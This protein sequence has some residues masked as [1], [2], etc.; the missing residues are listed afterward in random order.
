[1]ARDPHTDSERA[2]RSIAFTGLLFLAPAVALRA[3]EPPKTDERFD[4]TEAMVKM[5]DG[6]KLFTTL[7]VP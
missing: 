4:R 1:M 2:M 3:Q 5:R 6:V 7:H